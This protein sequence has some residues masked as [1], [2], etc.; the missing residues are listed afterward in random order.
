[1]EYDLSNADI[2]NAYTRVRSETEQLINGLSSEDCQIQSMPDASPTKWHL[3]HTTWFFET[4]ILLKYQPHYT[5]VDE[6]YAVLFNSYY[7]A[8]GAQYSRPKRGLLSRPT[9]DQVMEYRKEIDTRMTAFIQQLRDSNILK[10]ILLGLNHEQQHQE[11]ILTDIKHALSQNPMHPQRLKHYEFQDRQSSSLNWHSYQGGLVTMGA[12]TKAFSFDNERPQHQ[13][14]VAPFKLANRT[15]TNGEFLSFINDGGYQ[16]SLHWLSDG[17]EFVQSEAINSPLYWHQQGNQW[18]RYTMSGL[19]PLNLNEP[20][21]HISFYEASAF[22]SWSGKR[23]PT[24]FE[25]ELAATQSVTQAPQFDPMTLEPS[26]VEED[27]L[28][29]LLGGVWEWTNSSYLAYPGFK[30]F[31]GDAGEYNGKFMSGQFVLR[32]GS[33]FTPTGHIRNSYRNFFYPQQRWQMSGIR[34]AADLT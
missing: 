26:V 29:S 3:A 14:F 15:V 7:N 17:W 2:C 13:V 22:A 24:E 10:L 8:I 31:E 32:G 9:L 5:V 21:C 18:F 34:L 30:P 25:W 1:M 23:L 4:F 11:L 19:Q 28:Q 6:H 12:S 20:L 33:C 16:N 27:N